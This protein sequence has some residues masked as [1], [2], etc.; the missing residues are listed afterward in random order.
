M[1]EWMDGGWMGE[2][3]RSLALRVRI[4]VGCKRALLV[5]A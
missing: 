1:D 2:E 5:R 4:K 3:P